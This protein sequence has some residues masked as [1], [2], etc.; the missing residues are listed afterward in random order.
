M[1]EIKNQIAV[2]R[3]FAV[4][5]MIGVCFFAACSSE[6]QSVD[7]KSGG[8]DTSSQAKER[9]SSSKSDSLAK[10]GEKREREEKDEERKPKARPAVPVKVATLGTG[11]ISS[12][13]VFDSVL[14]TESSVEIYSE[15]QGVILEVLVEVGDR[16]VKGDVLARLESEEQQL[17]MEENKTRYEQ[18]KLSFQRSKELAERKLINQQEFE[19]AT[20][21]LEQARLRYERSKIRLENTIVRATVEGVVTERIAQVGRRVTANRQ[22]FALMN[23]DELYAEVNAPGQ[24]LLRISQGL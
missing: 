23:L 7:R 4:L 5:M 20:F 6:T 13:L 2:K 19:R 14:E 21:N 17:D 16:V 24:H 12:S 9:A 10:K 22:L 3:I 1:I 11:D 15:S 8:E 18:E